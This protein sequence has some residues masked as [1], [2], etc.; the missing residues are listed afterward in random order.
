MEK[1]I[2]DGRTDFET[3]PKYLKRNQPLEIKHNSFH[4]THPHCLNSKVFVT[5]DYSYYHNI[6]PKTSQ[7][8]RENRVYN[9]ENLL[10]W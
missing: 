10:G 6:L 8:K 1:Y 3:S 7:M 4:Q 2:F 9:L 5:F